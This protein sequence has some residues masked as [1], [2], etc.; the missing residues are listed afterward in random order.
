MVRASAERGTKAITQVQEE[1]R[2]IRKIPTWQKSLIFIS[3]CI[4]SPMI[5]FGVVGISADRGRGTEKER[6]EGEEQGA[7]SFKG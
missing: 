7:E 5:L 3:L 1:M 6:A 4:L 2:A